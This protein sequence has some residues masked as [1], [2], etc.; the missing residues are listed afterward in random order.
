VEVFQILRDNPLTARIPVIAI[1]ANALPGDIEAG[2]QAGFFRYLTKP[3]LIDDFM[4][5]L[6]QAL[7][8]NG[9]TDISRQ[10]RK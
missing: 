2:L 3:F 4:V 10:S 8:A 6:D 5:A 7:E 9:S 1:T